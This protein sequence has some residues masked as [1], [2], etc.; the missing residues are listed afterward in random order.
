MD[1]P[2]PGAPER[3]GP[4]DPEGPL[5]PVHDAIHRLIQ[6]YVVHLMDTAQYEGIAMYCCFLRYDVVHREGWGG[7]A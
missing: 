4:H 5:D 3:E 1:S 6:A 2:T 7:M